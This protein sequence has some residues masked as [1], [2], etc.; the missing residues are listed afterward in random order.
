MSTLVSF[1]YVHILSQ[2]IHRFHF[3]QIFEESSVFHNTLFTRA[4]QIAK[5]NYNLY[6]DWNG[7]FGQAAYNLYVSTSAQELLVSSQFMHHGID[8]QVRDWVVFILILSC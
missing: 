3:T 6:P 1:P 7:G 5:E 8:D 2:G 4:R